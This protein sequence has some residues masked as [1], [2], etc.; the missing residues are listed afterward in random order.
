LKLWLKD[1][2]DYVAKRGWT[3]QALTARV[4]ATALQLL[5]KRFAERRPGAALR[6]QR[7][8]LAN[9]FSVA[10]AL[11][12]KTQKAFANRRQR[13]SLTNAKLFANKRQVVR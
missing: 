7:E 11:H 5:A 10:W 3:P 8:T 4:M 9:A 13:C 2:L 6:Q 12:T 1:I